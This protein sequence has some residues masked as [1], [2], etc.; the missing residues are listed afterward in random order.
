MLFEI[1]RLW[2]KDTDWPSKDSFLA[3]SRAPPLFLFCLGKFFGQDLKNGREK[4]QRVKKKIQDSRYSVWYS[5]KMAVS[6]C[7][8]VYLNLAGFFMASK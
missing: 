3:F 6:K 2:G 4:K 5:S 7:I 1:R 8:P